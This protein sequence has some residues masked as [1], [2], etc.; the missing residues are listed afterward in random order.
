MTDKFWRYWNYTLEWE[1]LRKVILFIKTSLRKGVIVH[2][3]E[4]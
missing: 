4:G 2:L 1:W 3:G